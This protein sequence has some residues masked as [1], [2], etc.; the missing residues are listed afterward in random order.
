ML[1]QADSK[2]SWD[3]LELIDDFFPIPLAGSQYLAGLASTVTLG[4]AGG[5]AMAGDPSLPSS[6]NF[7]LL[8]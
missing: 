3:A 5:A 1:A 4:A 6:G 7:D 2:G 8:P